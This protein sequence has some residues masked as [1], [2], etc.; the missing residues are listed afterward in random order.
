M[1]N[2]RFII[3]LFALMMQFM[4]VMAETTFLF[5]VPLHS[6]K[7]PPYKGGYPVPHRAPAH[8][9]IPLEVFVDEMNQ[10]LLFRDSSMGEYIYR[11]YDE[12]GN[13]LVY[14]ELNFAETDNLSV[15][16]SYLD[17][18]YSLE[19]VSENKTFFGILQL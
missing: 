1:K 14:G 12:D 10:Q 3:I 5:P 2:V 11:I 19:V 9:I 4:C 15:D 7:L 8:D 16:I 13:F 17:G 18:S 6:R